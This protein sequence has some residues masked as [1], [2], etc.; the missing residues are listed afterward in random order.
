MN[1]QKFG[2]VFEG[3]APFIVERAVYWGAGRFGGHVSTGTPYTGARRARRSSRPR[4]RRLPPPP[5]PP[6]RLH[7]DRVRR[8]A[9]L[10]GRPGLRR[11]LRRLR[12][13]R[14]RRAT[15]AS[16]TPCRRSPRAIFEYELTGMRPAFNDEKYK[17][18]AMYDGDW[19]SGN[20][21]RATIE[22]R[23]PPRHARVQVPDRRRLRRQVRHRTA[24]HRGGHGDPVEPGR[25]LP[26]PRRVGR[27]PRRLRRSRRSRAAGSGR[28]AG[29]T[30]TPTWAGST[31]R[32]TTASPSATRAPA[33][34]STARSRACASATCGSAPADGRRGR[35]GPPGRPAARAPAEFAWR[36]KLAR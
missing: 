35:P 25:H 7:G 24:L 9:G 15:P 31:T 28:A 33:A 12:L 23:L 26:G 13:R 11:R 6:P 8:P 1:G 30:A 5:P 22:Q 36:D 3:S 4:R 20:L 19:S 14:H 17:I 2:A 16:N 27:R 21:Y 29:P 34:A 10:V 18:L 32:P